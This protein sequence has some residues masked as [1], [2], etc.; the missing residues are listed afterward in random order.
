MELTTEQNDILRTVSQFDTNIHINAVP[1]S[2]KTTTCLYIA[3]NNPSKRILLLTYNKRLR[4]ETLQKLNGLQ[5]I[6][7]HTFHSFGYS[8]FC[9]KRCKDDIGLN[10]IGK[11]NDHDISLYYDIVVGDS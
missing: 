1:G 2:A 8:G 11:C 7:C 5:N 9:E 4:L 3:K 10:C 6:E